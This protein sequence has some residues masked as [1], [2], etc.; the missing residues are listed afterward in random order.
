[1]S[2]YLQEPKMGFHE[3][4]CDPEELIQPWIWKMLKL[5]SIPYIQLMNSVKNGGYELDR[6]SSFLNLNSVIIKGE[7]ER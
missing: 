1:M 6:F 4:S 5:S 7:L 2:K 3:A